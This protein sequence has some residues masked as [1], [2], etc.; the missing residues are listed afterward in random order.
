MGTEGEDR[1]GGVA[2]A[3]SDRTALDCLEISSYPSKL[4]PF[5]RCSLSA[6]PDT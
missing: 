6:L 1:L 3:G 5:F 4:T 2:C